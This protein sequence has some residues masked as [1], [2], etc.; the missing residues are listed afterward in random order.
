MGGGT[1]ISKWLRTWALFP[2]FL[3]GLTALP[4]DSLPPVFVVDVENLNSAAFP[5][6][7]KSVSPDSSTISTTETD[8]V[9]TRPEGVEGNLLLTVIFDEKDGGFLRVYRKNQ[10]QAQ[11]ISENL[12][13]GTGMAN[14]RTLLISGIDAQ[15]PTTIVLQSSGASAVRR[16][17]W[18]WPQT[19]QVPVVRVS[20]ASVVIRHDAILTSDEVSGQ[21][22]PTPQPGVLIDYTSTPLLDQPAQIDGSVVFKAS[23]DRLPAYV[24]LEGKVS[25]LSLGQEL[26]C[27]INGQRAGVFALSL[28][29]LRDP[30]YLLTPGIAPGLAGWRPGSLYIP[31]ALW[32]S[33]E[34]EIEI[35]PAGSEAASYAIKDMVLELVYADA[36]SIT[37]TSASQ[38][39]ASAIPSNPSP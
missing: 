34:N 26:E 19:Q 25:G 18:E 1:W 31:A 20:T 7:L 23:L 22:L 30:A 36:S 15:S 37:V 13:E 39:P 28:P 16:L 8:F 32:T 24:R 14:Q 35:R 38:T 33:G 5:A 11:T 29:S 21:P 27:W 6:W 17:V 2:L 4:A 3:S 12:Y 10:D 9:V